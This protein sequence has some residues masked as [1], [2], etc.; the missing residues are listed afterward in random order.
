MYKRK[1]NTSLG[2]PLISSIQIENH[3]RDDE[4][5]LE[6]LPSNVPKRKSSVGKSPSAKTQATNKSDVLE[7][8]NILRS[9]SKLSPD[10]SC[11]PKSQ[12]V[13]SRN[14]TSVT[15]KSSTKDKTAKTQTQDRNNEWN[16]K[17][18]RNPN[19]IKH[20]FKEVLKEAG[21]V[22][23][24]GDGPHLL[25]SSTVDSGVGK[26]QFAVQIVC[27]NLQHQV[28]C[29]CKVVKSSVL[30]YSYTAFVILITQNR[31]IECENVKQALFI[32]EVE[33]L[34]TD[35]SARCT[36]N[37]ERFLNEL[38][39]Y[40]KDKNVL[41]KS[42]E[43]T[44]GCGLYESELESILG[45][46]GVGNI[47]KDSEPAPLL[48]I[49][50]SLE[51]SILRFRN[52][53]NY[54]VT[55]KTLDGELLSPQDS[56]IHMLLTIKCVQPGLIE[57][58]FHKIAE[59]GMGHHWW[60]FM[61]RVGDEGGQKT[62]KEISWV[63]LILKQ[64]KF[65]GPVVKPLELN[66]W[67]FQLLEGVPHNV[68]V[69]M[70][71]LFQDIVDS[72]YHEECAKKF[73]AMLREYHRL[74]PALLEM[75][76]SLDI[77]PELQGEL[78]QQMLKILPSV[79]MENL[80]TLVT[81]LQV[82]TSAPDLPQVVRALRKHLNFYP[83]DRK[84][85]KQYAEQVNY[86]L[87]TAESLQDSMLNSEPLVSAWLKLV[88]EAADTSEHN[89]MDVIM[90]LLLYST[91]S[92]ENKKLAKKVFSSKVRSG[93]FTPKLLQAVFERH[94]SI[95]EKYLSHTLELI[96]SFI[97]SNDPGLLNH[98]I[99]WFRLCVEH[100]D[101][102]SCQQVVRELLLLV[103][104]DNG[105]SETFLTLLNEIPVSKLAP[106]CLG[107]M[108]LLPLVM[109]RELGEVR[110]IMEL[111]CRVVYSK[112]GHLRK[113]E[114]DVHQYLRKLKQH[115]EN[116][117][118]LKGVISSVVV[119]K[120]VI[121]DDESSYTATSNKDVL[122]TSTGET[123]T[124]T[125]RASHA[126]SFLDL[127]SKLCVNNKIEGSYYEDMSSALISIRKQDADRTFLIWL[128]D[129]VS[130]EFESAYVNDVDDIKLGEELS[131]QFRLDSNATNTICI[132]IGNIV[133]KEM[134]TS[135]SNFRFSIIM[136]CPIFKL[137]RT[138]LADNLG[139]IDALL[140][141]GVP[142]PNPETY[143]E[144]YMMDPNEQRFCLDSWF[145]CI[146]WFIE[147]VNAFS[148][149]TDTDN[150]RKVCC[151]L[152]QIIILLELV[153]EKLPKSH[154]YKPPN[155]KFH[156]DCKPKPLGPAKSK[157][158]A[159][160][161]TNQL[162]VCTELSLYLLKKLVP[163]K[164][165]KADKQE[166]N[167]TINGLA[168][169]PNIA[170]A[171]PNQ[172][173]AYAGKRVMWWDVV[174]AY[175]PFFQELEM[176][177]F[178][179]LSKELRAPTKTQSLKNDETDEPELNCGSLLFLL[180]DYVDKV[181]YMLPDHTK[182]IMPFKFASHKDVCF[183][184]VAKVTP[185]SFAKTA[186]KNLDVLCVKLE[187]IFERSCP[188]T[189]GSMIGP[190]MFE[191][192]TASIKLCCDYLL[193]G[194]SATF[195]WEGLRHAEH[196]NLLKAAL[197]RL[198]SRI[199]HQYQS[200][201][202]KELLKECC[203]YVTSFESKV[204]DVQS[205]SSLV[206][207]LHTLIGF[208]VGEE[209]QLK[210]KLCEYT[211][212]QGCRCAWATICHKYLTQ[213]WFTLH[214]EEESG[215]QFNRHIA[216]FLQMY[217]TNV[218]RAF[219]VVREIA[220][221]VASES[222]ALKTKDDTL[223]SFP[224][225]KRS[226]LSTLL[227]NLFA[228]LITSASEKL[229]QDSMTNRNKM[230][231]WKDINATIHKFMAILRNVS[232]NVNRLAFLKEKP[233]P[234]HPTEIRTSISPS[235]AV[236]LNTSSALA[237]YT[238]EAGCGLRFTRILP[239]SNPETPSDT[240]LIHP[241]VWTKHHTETS[242][243][244]DSDKRLANSPPMLK[245]YLS[246]AVPTWHSAFRN[247]ADE[248]MKDVNDMQVFTRFIYTLANVGKME[249]NNSMVVY[250]A[251]AK[252]YIVKFM[253]A[254]KGVLAFHDCLDAFWSGHLKNKGLDGKELP[255]QDITSLPTDDD[256]AEDEEEE[257]TNE[258]EEGADGSSSVTGAA[259][260]VEENERF[261]EDELSEVDLDPEVAPRE[262]PSDMESR[263]CIDSFWPY[264]LTPWPSNK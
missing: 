44:H 118:K 88:E 165:K 138:L 215:P 253:F 15:P 131:L 188:K 60:V 247:H 127:D 94:S 117:F 112:H 234:V 120:N 218:P 101:S 144:F 180:M 75:L 176:E 121:I 46:V 238:T 158:G 123:V 95:V 130:E 19:C 12:K 231:L 263:K 192:S 205:A 28:R 72:E 168:P 27:C 36:N 77:S 250:T 217:L 179:L 264:S 172:G 80:P 169:V 64:L 187:Q 83:E 227:N 249:E 119:A 185:V 30:D 198:A 37:I 262:D 93:T 209:P 11:D 142:M 63:Q 14:V 78:T 224:A 255:S 213:T 235:S 89:P 41:L 170:S 202:I 210:E 79:P 33:K 73:Q 207:L 259:S 17:R 100:L 173:K 25:G 242:Y 129:K 13:L 92:R 193:R 161:S 107:V 150:I 68:Q 240:S 35:I 147:L 196:K 164:G 183:A 9:S 23:S 106:Q 57:F 239:Q 136:L 49:G 70:I 159:T 166:N 154:D 151:R 139:A 171:K 214:G 220:D 141:C 104:Q 216:L 167:E 222:A 3:L 223:K 115:M 16:L 20:Y 251:H 230:Q 58:L 190:G 236:E 233:P 163:R 74:I 237:N 152:D 189:T 145:H 232:T 245:L 43:P 177:V 102:S 39:E 38:K 256:D 85:A 194:L 82:N 134:K 197:R 135:S 260:V 122:E 7:T 54:W 67:Y 184:N 5:N 252:A 153:A 128:T 114:D 65:I 50:C 155:C 219:D 229:N 31:I 110:Q 175:K 87:L 160:K 157:K 8:L 126:K 206:K 261:S 225:I 90:L 116:S 149:H 254:M 148:T 103:V 143:E 191:E 133:E 211:L 246:D 208:S 21:L 4:D 156:Y 201:S 98:A 113:L 52:S 76:R 53:G 84:H 10:K 42:L 18:T 96:S 178:V 125:P 62:D 34:L 61:G 26:G 241:M 99:S 51:P 248:V 97:K 105:H 146:N 59:L 195:S 199:N 186:I 2:T 257:E 124:L 204:L 182:R 56:L 258:L 221:T 81:F 66:D 140:G 22:F 212:D 48:A 40:C 32:N 181:E 55:P 200:L 69:D 6:L 243:V 71:I 45:E 244:Y 109:E 1:R 228:S 132:Q 47:N 91:N 137:L 108:K 162:L 86:Q 203:E 174:T 111:I 29:K 24:D 226:N